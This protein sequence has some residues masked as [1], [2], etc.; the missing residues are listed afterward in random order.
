MKYLLFFGLL[1]T[2]SLGYAQST[3]ADEKAV[4]D[5]EKARFAAQVS[6]DLTYLDKVLASDLVY[7][8]S[9]GKTDTKQAFIQSIKDGSMQYNSID[10]KELKAR[11][12][13]KTAILNGVCEIK[14]FTNGQP[15]NTSFRY[16]DVYVKN[17]N[18]WQLVTWQSLRLPN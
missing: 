8:H 4:L 9:S 14:A 6:K 16:T 5:V 12:Y 18:Q 15:L 17:G 10:S 11:I 13:G 2:T 3:S 1:I 7:I